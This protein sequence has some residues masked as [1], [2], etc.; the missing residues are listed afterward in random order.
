MISVN[1]TFKLIIAA[2]CVFNTKNSYLPSLIILDHH[3]KLPTILG[4]TRSSR[5]KGV[6]KKS[7]LI[8]Q[9]S[10]YWNFTEDRAWI[11]TGEMPTSAQ[12]RRNIKLWSS[13]VSSHNLKLTIFME[14]CNG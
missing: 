6:D 14:M 11:S 10:S 12:Q 1:N 7:I 9:Q 8:S 2:N 4:L 5:H 13:E 3:R